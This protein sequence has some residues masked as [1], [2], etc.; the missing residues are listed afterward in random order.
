MVLIRSPTVSLPSE[1]KVVVLV[2]SL[3]VMAPFG[4]MPSVNSDVPVVSGT[5]PVPIA[6]VATAGVEGVDG[7]ELDDAT[8]LDEPVD[9]ELP[10]W[11]CCN[12][13]WIAAVS[14]VLVR[15]SAVWLARLARPWVSLVMALPMEL[16]SAALAVWVCDCCWPRAQKF[17]SCC[18]NEM[19]PMLI[20]PVALPGTASPRR[21]DS[22]SAVNLTC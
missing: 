18:Q 11:V 1:A 22:R 10:V 5:V 20:G 19:L 13:L 7:L 9:D 17:W 6:G 12:S 14:A 3:T 8:A 21:Y 2:P 15:L 4:G 16:I